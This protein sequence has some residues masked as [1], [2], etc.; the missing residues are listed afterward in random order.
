[1]TTQKPKGTRLASALAC[2]IV[3]AS[4]AAGA[5]EKVA[6]P[7]TPDLPAP[8][9]ARITQIYRD[10]R[11]IDDIVRATD[12]VKGEVSKAG[13]MRSYLSKLHN[14]IALS[15]DAAGQLHTPLIESM[16]AK[17]AALGVSLADIDARMVNSLAQ[18][19]KA[20]AALQGSYRSAQQVKTYEGRY[21]EFKIASVNAQEIAKS[22]DRLSSNIKSVAASCRPSTIPP[23]FE[24]KADVR[25]SDD[26]RQPTPPPQQPQAAQRA[27]VPTPPPPAPSSAQVQQV[28]NVAPRPKRNYGYQPYYGYDFR[29]R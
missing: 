26:P 13:A 28:Q 8:D 9:T 15:C 12:F 23:L 20:T 17:T 14:A 22:V 10:A 19:K 25:A 1:M 29:Y 5:A 16:T 11:T 2:C 3:C 4:G 18:Q 21:A 6:T 27:T 7:N 24:A